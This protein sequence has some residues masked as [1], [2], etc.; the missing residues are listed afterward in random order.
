M[1][2]S[3]G[4]SRRSNVPESRKIVLQEGNQKQASQPSSGFLIVAFLAQRLPVRL[5]PEQ[6]LIAPVRNEV[7]YHRRGHDLSLCL[8]EGTQRMLLQEKSAGF[9]PTGIVTSPFSVQSS[10]VNSSKF[11]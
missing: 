5:V 1:V 8:A 3:Q 7:I 6:P 10:S 2:G 11:G 9:A 4:N